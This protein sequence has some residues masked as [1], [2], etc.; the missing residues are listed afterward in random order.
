[1]FNFRDPAQVLSRLL[2]Y[3][4][5]GYPED[6]LLRYQKAIK[7]V[8]IADVQRVATTYLAPQKLVTLV[9]GNASAIQPPLSSLGNNT[10]VTSID[11]TIPEPAK[12]S[13]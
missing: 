7:T 4:Y 3:T 9:V 2:R 8:T 11:I 6:F 1:V 10:P 5:Y 12:S 13:L